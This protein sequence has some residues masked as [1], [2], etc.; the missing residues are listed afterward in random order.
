VSVEARN[1]AVAVLRDGGSIYIR[2]IHPE[3][4][5]RLSTTSIA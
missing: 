5:A 4:R 2:A 3:D 1:Y